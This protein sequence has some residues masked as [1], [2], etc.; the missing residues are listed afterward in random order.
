MLHTKTNLNIVTLNKLGH[1]AEVPLTDAAS[2]GIHMSRM[3]SVI[4]QLDGNY[5]VEADS[6]ELYDWECR[7]CDERGYD[8]ESLK[9]HTYF[10][11]TTRSLKDYKIYYIDDDRIW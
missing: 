7:E 9:E 10:T 8:K 5:E 11:V 1:A 3:H 6:A 4:E 2:K